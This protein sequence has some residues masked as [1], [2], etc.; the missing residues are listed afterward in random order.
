M[1][2]CVVCALTRVEHGTLTAAGRHPAGRAAHLAAPAACPA[3][4]GAAHRGNTVYVLLVI[5]V[6]ATAAILA[7]VV[8][9]ALGRAGE[10]AHFPGDGPPLEPDG[11]TAADVALYRPPM[12]FWGYYVP[13][14]E[15]AFQLIARTVKAKDEQIAALRRELDEARGEAAQDTWTAPRDS[16]ARPA[17]R[18]QWAEAD[19]IWAESDQTWGLARQAWEEPGDAGS[20]DAG[21]VDART[22]ETPAAGTPAT[23]TPVP[24]TSIAETRAA[25]IPIAETP[26]A[27]NPIAE[28]PV[29]EIPVAGSSVSEPAVSEPSAGEPGREDGAAAAAD[30]PHTPSTGTDG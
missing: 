12:A 30:R 29:A 23:G 24:G 15:E 17:P 3:G 5:L 18:P 21:S 22:V 10:M 4:A 20:V 2:R 28:I 6:L 13:A 8:F 19:N 26:A 27:G 16:W 14:V 11:L 25:E 1:R 9:A 7:G